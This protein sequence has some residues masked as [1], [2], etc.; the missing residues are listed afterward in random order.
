MQSIL[1]EV[2][3]GKDFIKLMRQ[4]S[5]NKRMLHYFI[6]ET[7][8][9]IEESYRAAALE[10]KNAGDISDPVRLE[11]GVCIIYLVERP[12]PGQRPLEL[13]YD[14]IK[15]SLTFTANTALDFELW[16]EYAKKAEDEG[17]VELFIDKL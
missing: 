5:E 17:I 6:Y 1:E 15:K 16:N 14:E 3:S 12:E 7:S 10:L 4:K 2:R 13:V 8:K 9:H 11:Q